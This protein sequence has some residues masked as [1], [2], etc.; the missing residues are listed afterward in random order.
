[1]ASASVFITC[2]KIGFGTILV[3]TMR[4]KTFKSKGYPHHVKAKSMSLF[5]TSGARAVVNKEL[6]PML[7]ARIGKAIAT[8]VGE[9]Q[10]LIGYDTRTSSPMI[11]HALTA[12]LLSNDVKVS[13]QGLVPTPL[14][15]FLTKQLK[16]DIGIMI[17]ASHN[18]PQY[19]GIKLFNKDSTPYNEKQQNQIEKIVKREKYKKTSWH[20]MGT[21]TAIDETSKYIE[22]IEKTVKLE[23]P[24]QIVL[25]L[26]CG[27]TSHIA[28]LIFRKLGCKVTAINAQPDGFFSGRKPEPDSESLK[29][30]CEIVPRLGAEAGIAYDGD[31]D[32]MVAI[33][34]K[35]KICSFDQTLAAYSAYIIRKSKGGIIVTHVEASMCMERMVEQFFGKVIRTKVGDI[36]IAAAIKRNKAI[37]GGEPCGAWIHPKHHF[38]PDGILSSVLLLKALEE[39]NKSLSTFISEVPA[40]PI[41][42]ENFPCPNEM[43]NAV[44]ERISK[45][46]PSFFKEI[47][48]VSKIDG[49]RL[50]LKNG[51]ILIRPSGTEPLTRLTVEAETRREAEEI[52]KKGLRIVEESV[53]ETKK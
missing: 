32:R 18:P 19:N 6:T 2:E 42:R 22:M 21:K 25:D 20:Q 5:G 26:G 27:A 11:L 43:K 37:F 17:T 30:L 49:I 36:H 23:K 38:C 35:G 29:S 44:M 33:D 4:V 52:L 24:W 46:F 15:A 50:T 47:L 14:L 45:M 34:E 10:A 39:E 13:I 31:G 40:Y 7:V 28:P 9:G 8:H 3:F 41:L 51:W 12:G 1:M 53:K 48:N 16:S